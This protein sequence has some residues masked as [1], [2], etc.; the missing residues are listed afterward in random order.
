MRRARVITFD[1][2]SAD[3]FTEGFEADQGAFYKI[4]AREPDDVAL[5]G[6]NT[7]LAVP[8]ATPDDDNADPPAYPQ[9]EGPVLAVID[10]R[11]RFRAWDWLRQQPPWREVVAI[12]SDATPPDV[13]MRWRKRALRAFFTRGDKVDLAVALDQ[14]TEA[15]SAER[16]R[17]ESGG[18]LN[19]LLMDQGLIDEAAMLV[20]PVLAGG[21]RRSMFRGPPGFEPKHGAKLKLRICERLD[22]DLIHLRYD[23]V[24]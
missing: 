17:I 16:I 21:E 4:V 5:A 2:I 1:A 22:G 6:S 24:R 13:R 20:H 14:L 8:G 9:H 3:G 18:T 12:G 10:S 7:I 11:G 19:G 15:Y 23:I